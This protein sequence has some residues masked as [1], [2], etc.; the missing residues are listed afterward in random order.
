MINPEDL[1]KLDDASL[2][3]LLLI[4][5]TALL[6]CLALAND[7]AGDEQVPET[8]FTQIADH[9]EMQGCLFFVLT[10]RSASQSP[11]DIV[12]AMSVK[13]APAEKLKNSLAIRRDFLDRVESQIRVQNALRQFFLAEADTGAP[14][15]EEVARAG[16]DDHESMLLYL[17]EQGRALRKEILLITK[18]FAERAREIPPPPPA[19]RP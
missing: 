16:A 7:H 2:D 6:Q 15:S 19:R 9:V 1:T 17:A 13:M 10:R 14:S 4:R 18:E 12:D 8:I 11:V 3:E 5:T